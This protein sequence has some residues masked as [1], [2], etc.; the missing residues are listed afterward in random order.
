MPTKRREIYNLANEVHITFNA[1]EKEK[2]EFTLILTSEDEASSFADSLAKLL[3]EVDMKGPY[4]DIRVGIFTK[5]PE[6]YGRI[7]IGE[8]KYPFSC[9]KGTDPCAFYE[10]FSHEVWGDTAD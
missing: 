7:Q 8:K 10:S 1:S 2:G 5:Q 3:K 6:G 4:K 9:G